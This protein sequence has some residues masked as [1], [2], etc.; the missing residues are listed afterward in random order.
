MGIMSRNQPFQ[1]L[2]GSSSSAIAEHLLIA[3]ERIGNQLVKISE[4]TRICPM[5][6]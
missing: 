5:Y 1:N 6:G 3:R 2:M 4:R